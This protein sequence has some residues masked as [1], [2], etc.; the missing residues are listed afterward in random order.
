[1]PNGPP[2]PSNPEVPF[3]PKEYP[4]SKAQ[5]RVWG[6]R[7]QGLG[8]FSPALV[9]PLHLAFSAML[10]RWLAAAALPAVAAAAASCA[11]EGANQTVPIIR[12]V[13]NHTPR[14]LSSKPQ[15]RK[16][17]SSKAQTAGDQTDMMDREYYRMLR[18]PRVDLRQMPR[19][20][21]CFC[22]FQKF[23]LPTPRNFGATEPRGCNFP[24]QG[25]ST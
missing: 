15:A 8:R 14:K 19:P 7:L 3:N 12:V 9:F 11:A 6:L 4:H 24:F 13:S 21:C 23:Q 1:M 2:R 17:S 22:K 25:R 16:A 18:S 5:H 20:S 10:L